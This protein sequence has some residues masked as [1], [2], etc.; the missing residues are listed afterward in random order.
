[1]N[2][3][4]IVESPAKA[5]TIEGF[6]GS[7][8]IVKS[9]YGHIR[10]LPKKGDPIDIENNFNP[11]YVVPQEKKKVVNELLSIAKK[12]KTCFKFLTTCFIF[13]KVGVIS[14]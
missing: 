3:L 6:L 1:M 8:F 10:E 9:C 14:R 7:E 11:T 12:C 13:S 2:N 5:K 4:V